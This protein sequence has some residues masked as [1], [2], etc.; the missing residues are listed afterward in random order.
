MAVVGNA[1]PFFGADTSAA[2]RLA[3][4]ILLAAFLHGVVVVGLKLPDPAGTQVPPPLRLS[5]RAPPSPASA[6]LSVPS[7]KSLPEQVSPSDAR[8]LRAAPAAEPA[9][10]PRVAAPE[11]S[12]PTV[13]PL[14][15]QTAPVVESARPPVSAD[16]FD[17]A[18][19][20]ARDIGRESMRDGVAGG[21]TV[22]AG[23][24]APA[25][26][27]RAA[28]PEL[29]RA[30]RKRSASEERLGGGILRITTESGRVYCLKPPSDAVRDGPVEP[31]AVATNCP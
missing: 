31:L 30:L 15:T 18:R 1:L 3:P 21:T 20:M 8:S 29:D 26:V 5:W 17:S 16:L 27:E 12:V 23:R 9:R 25:A 7:S 11:V 10:V 13:P 6:P 2:R 22:G 28:L 19:R 4:Y 14:A 24:G